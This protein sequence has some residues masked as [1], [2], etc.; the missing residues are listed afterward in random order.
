LSTD[1]TSGVSI[2]SFTIAAL[3]VESVTRHCSACFGF[4]NWGAIVSTNMSATSAKVGNCFCLASRLTAF[5]FSSG[6]APVL[7]NL[8]FLFAS[9]GASASD[10]SADSEIIPALVPR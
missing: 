10:T 5:F 2:L 7:I 6:S 9:S 8:R 1:R 4:R 3:C